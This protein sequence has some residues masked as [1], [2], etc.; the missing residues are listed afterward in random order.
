[1][2]HDVRDE[3]VDF[4]RHWSAKTEIACK[5]FVRWLGISKGKYYDWLERCGKVNEHNGMIPRDHWLEPWEREAILEYHEQRSLGSVRG[6]G[7]PL[8]PRPVPTATTAYVLRHSQRKQGEQI[9][10]TYKY[11]ASPRP[12]RGST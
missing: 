10:Q 12:Y 5:R 9:G 3:V 6:A 1:M 8:E 2:P 4:V 7:R 11:R